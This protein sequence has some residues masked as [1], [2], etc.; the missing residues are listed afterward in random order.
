MLYGRQTPATAL[1]SCCPVFHSSM[2]PAAEI[3]PHPL[4]GMM[5]VVVRIG[6]A[7]SG[8][9]DGL[10]GMRREAVFRNRQPLSRE[11]FD[12][13]EHRSLVAIAKGH[14]D[15]CGTGPSGP[16]DAMN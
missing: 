12:V 16:P 13:S 3:L 1:R 15:S 9:G 4:M 11:P 2:W 8:T 6:L 5:R 14:G 10:G 7:V